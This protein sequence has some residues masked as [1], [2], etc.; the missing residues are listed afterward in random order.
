MVAGSRVGPQTRATVGNRGAAAI[1]RQEI[2]SSVIR[3]ARFE[4]AIVAM[5]TRRVRCAPR[6]GLVGE[7]Q[8]NENV[9]QKTFHKACPLRLDPKFGLRSSSQGHALHVDRQECLLQV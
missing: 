3:C 9:N 2:L 7:R 6:R 5:D 8:M 4:S 1:F